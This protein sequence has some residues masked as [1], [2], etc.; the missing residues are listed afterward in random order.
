M[1][2]GGMHPDPQ[3]LVHLCPR[4]DW[5]SACA[6]GELR[7]ESLAAGGF[8]HL[9]T[10]QQVHLPANRIFA[11]R[12]DLVILYLDV[13]RLGAPVRWEPGVAT[14]PDGMLFPHLYGAIPVAAVVE[15]QPYSPDGNGRFPP[16]VHRRDEGGDE[17]YSRPRGDC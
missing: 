10:R 4:R 15:A 12:E 9:S 8:V 6:L 16:F 14:D 11:G 2:S 1:Q 13:D 7:P 5:E 17:R 3:L